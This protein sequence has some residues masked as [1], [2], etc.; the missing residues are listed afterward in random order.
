MIRTVDA[1]RTPRQPASP[2]TDRVVAVMR[3]LGSQPT[4][5]FSLAEITRE[6]GISRATGHAILTTLAAHHWV[7]RDFDTAAYSWGPGIAALAKPAGD[8]AFRGVL[9]QLAESTAAQ[10][11]LARREGNAIVVTDSAG[12]SSSGMRIDRGL[13]MP[14]VAPFGRD[15]IA[16]SPTPAQRAWLRGM[17]RPSAA[18][19]RR[20]TAVL[21]E[22]RQ[23]GYTVERLSREYLQV[24][25]ALRALRGDGEPDAIT[26]HLARAF[27][28]LTVI[29]VLDAE[30]AENEAHSIA[31][32]SAP[33]F[34][35]DGVVTMSISAAPFTDLT[36]ADVTRLSEQV[37]AA[38]RRIEPQI[39]SPT[40]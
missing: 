13:R 21:N 19:S 29:D 8:R 38:A 4:R 27:A 16:W 15:Y 5:A 26:A 39:A 14:L 30:L 7:V 36:T 12:E 33:I 31:T 22:I 24:Y 34:D 17:G 25:T 10:A 40:S 9:Q 23:R 1:G 6:L 32:I 11:F 28:D 37:C 18:L 35:D 20:I 3:L 2:P